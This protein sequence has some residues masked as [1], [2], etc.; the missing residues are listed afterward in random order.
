MN[1]LACTDAW[2][3]YVP[4]STN[5]PGDGFFTSRPFTIEDINAAWV[6]GGK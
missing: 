3:A 5:F 6:S 4:D 2:I 1:V